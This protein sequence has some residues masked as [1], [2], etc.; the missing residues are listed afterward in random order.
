MEY[1]MPVYY[2]QFQCIADACPATCCAGWAIVIDEKTMQKYHS[3]TG[4]AAFV[5]DRIDQEEQVFRRQNGRCAF[6]R[7]DG[8][9]EMQCRL[10]E[11]MLCKTCARYPRHFEE[12]GNL[13]E[14]ALSM[15]CP[16]AAR[17]ILDRE[18]TDRYRIRSTTRQSPHR[19]EVDAALLANLVLIRKK[20]FDITNDRR[21]PLMVRMMVI[22]DYADRVQDS[23]YQYEKLDWKRAIAGRGKA[24]LQET[25]A[26]PVKASN[27][28]DHTV[29]PAEN[30]DVQMQMHRYMD[31]LSGLENI[32]ADWPAWMEQVCTG[33]Y[34]DRDLQQYREL[35]KQ[36]AAYIHTSMYEYEHILN[37]FLYTYF[38]GGVYDYNILG[39]V[40]MSV[41]STLIIYELGMYAF[42]KQRDAFSLEDRI[43]IAYRYSRQV[44]HSDDNLLA[45]EGLL[46]AHPLF[47][48]KQMCSLLTNF[49]DDET[50]GV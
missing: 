37:Y 7:E 9:C 35:R 16:E 27:A 36:Y 40:K 18:Q 1:R 49:A 19:K 3:L 41:L 5:Q 17:M 28:T 29:Y 14:A 50:E 43:R 34:Q 48:T 13:C 20:I 12:Y 6:L 8:L 32:D 10:G 21:S 38:L 44:E 46:T 42:S 4:E 25:A 33:L 26:I 24:L 39:M 15:S 45:L 11:D 23:L 30:Q 47:A 2:K 22:A 31:M